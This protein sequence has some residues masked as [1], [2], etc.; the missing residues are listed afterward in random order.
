MPSA[1]T[2]A[3]V[4]PGR[5]ETDFLQI[6]DIQGLDPVKAT[7]NTTPYA[8]V[9][10]ESID[11]SQVPSRNI[12]MNVRPNPDWAT[13][14]PEALRQLLY[15]YFMPKSTVR[16]AFTSDELPVV[17]IFGVVDTIEANPFS[18]DP[19]FVISLI[20]SDPY[21]TKVEETV[22]SGTA[23]TAG[24]SFTNVTIDSNVELGLRTT[25][26]WTTT[27]PAFVSVQIKAPSFIS[28]DVDLTQNAALDSTKRFELSSVPKDKFVFAASP[29]N[30]L[31]Y[32]LLPWIN[33]SSVWPTL[34]QGVNQFA[35][36]T[37][38]GGQ[39]WDL[40]YHEKYGGF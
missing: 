38:S 20:C 1:P 34:K 23:I 10:G 27:K 6:T 39:S 29:D 33:E 4:I 25:L 21:F 13:W 9:D 32:Y 24:G 22:V 5:E 26:I 3:L 30:G 31:F 7:V 8:S 37:D 36:V 40:R 12:V 17:E 18:Q 15:S 14:T 28:F 11:G 16:L 2:L 35:I 19:E